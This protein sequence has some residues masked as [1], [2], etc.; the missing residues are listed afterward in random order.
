[1]N[2]ILNFIEEQILWESPQRA[3]RVYERIPR[4][5]LEQYRL[6]N[7][8]RTLKLVGERS[9]F[10][11]KKFGDYP[12][13]IKD[14]QSPRDLYSIFTSEKDIT[15]NPASHFI[16]G[17]SDTA[18]EST[19]TSSKTPKRI[20][21]SN[22]EVEDAGRIGAAGLWRLG[23]RRQDRVASAFD[24]SFWVSGPALKCSLAILGSFHIEAGRIDPED[25]Y[26][27]IK[28]Y[29]CNVI[30]ADPGWLVRLSEVAE[31]RGAWPM[32]LMIVGGENLSEM[33]RRY[34]EAVWLSKVLLS[35]GQTEA[36]G[37]I[38]VECHQQN[39]YHVNDMDLWVEIPVA[40]RE[41][42]GELVYTTL[43]RTVM[44]LVRYRSGDVTRIL[45]D[46]CP[47]G[48]PSI[49]LEKL[50]RRV[51]ELAVTGAGNLTPWMFQQMIDDLGLRLSDWQICLKHRGRRDLIEF[52][53]EGNSAT[54][55]EE[56]RTLFLN[57]MKKSMP[58]A[59]QGI[60]KGLSEFS[61]EIY[62]TGSLRQGRKVKRIIDERDFQKP[63]PLFTGKEASIA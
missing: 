53:M 21:F 24:N 57:G 35:Y 6:A 47:C 14:I 56:L 16:C 4:W 11:A 43:R 50:R 32:K 28:P 1:M 34:V 61:V 25:F 22:R 44:P 60:V 3:M 2:K 15:Q 7:L 30:V 54:S 62:S 46:K 9:I 45:T 40:D 33:S 20:F 12:F 27:R 8:R 38:G 41:G 23:L 26:D 55:Q 48:M 10:Y 13:R 5:L 42:T 49:R 52:R 51:D 31:Q 19:G 39:G 58:V 18:F 59:Y 36:F 17:R 63:A 37:M 29:Q